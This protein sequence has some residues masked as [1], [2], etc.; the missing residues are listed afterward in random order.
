M[1]YSKFGFSLFN[2]IIFSIRYITAFLCLG[3]LNNTSAVCLE[4][5]ILNS[6][7][8]YQKHNNTKNVYHIV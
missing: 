4:G 2:H 1:T 5:A 6:K 8:T 3:T 7:I